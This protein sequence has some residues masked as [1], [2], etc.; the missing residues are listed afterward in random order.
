MDPDQDSDLEQYFVRHESYAA[1]SFFDF[2]SFLGE[3]SEYVGL[4]FCLLLEQIVLKTDF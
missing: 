3:Q 1:L 2:R 4:H